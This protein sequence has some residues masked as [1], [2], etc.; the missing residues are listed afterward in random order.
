MFLSKS[1]SQYWFAVLIPSLISAAIAQETVQPTATPTPNAVEEEADEKE[2]QIIVTPNRSPQ[3]IS[4][5][6]S[7]VSVV[8]RE[9]IAAKKAIELSEIVR[10]APSLSVG[11]TGTLGKSASVFIRGANSNHTLVLIDGIRANSPAD[12]RFDFGA[13]QPE[14]IERIEVLR[15]P[16]SALYGSDAIGGVIN[17]ITRRGEG[18]LRTGGSIEFGNQSTN[19][20][21]VTAQG[22]VGKG[23]LSFSASR[24]KTNGFFANDDYNNIGASLRYDYRLSD[25]SNLTFTSRI[26]DGEVGTPGQRF[27]SYDPNAR[28]FPRNLFGSVQWTNEAK[29]GDEV[30]RRDRISLGAYDRKL[31]F[32]DP[33][34][35]GA[36]FPSFTNSNLTYKIYQLEAQSTLMRGAHAITL[37]GEVRSEKSNVNSRSTF[38]NN[39]LNNST[40]TQALWIQDEFRAGR[41]SLVPGLRLE[42]NSQFGSDLNGRLAAGYELNPKTRIKGSFGT[43]FSAPSFND[44]YFPGYGNANLKPEESRGFDIGI[45]R[46]LGRGGRLE[47]MAFSNRITNLIAA[48]AVPQPAPNPPLYQAANIA[49]ARTQGIELAWQQPLRE[50]LTLNVN[51]AFLSTSN[52]TSALI[53]RPR[54]ASNADL[55]YQRDRISADLGVV[56]QGRFVDFGATGTGYQPGFVRFDLTLGYNV[57]P[58][59]QIFT[60]VQNIFDKNYAEAA[61]FP[62]QGLNF[63]VGVQTRAF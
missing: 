9:Q 14:N 61:G 25:A 4:E 7:A 11:Q 13:L 20:Q 17:I 37:G 5:S 1:H 12:R 50:G 55:I 49:R 33:I 6:T 27:T 36:A 42:N 29:S 16:Q 30:R 59:V 19:R 28:S 31:R 51:H 56:A 32:D 52:G 2:V 23:A 3:A 39:L 47:V 60:R 10:L 15:G 44:L 43:G 40:N 41:F 26:D 57:R 34:N 45:E 21:I 48:V 62:A 58:E 53:R 63:V 22:S 24:I 38:G 18:P 46:Q 8:P 35:P 54:F